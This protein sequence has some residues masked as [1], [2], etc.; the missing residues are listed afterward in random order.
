[1]QKNS[2]AIVCIV[3]G[4]AIAFCIGVGSMGRLLEAVCPLS[5][6]VENDPIF[7]EL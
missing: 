2:F 7:G 3:V 6:M 4:L 5:G 1:M